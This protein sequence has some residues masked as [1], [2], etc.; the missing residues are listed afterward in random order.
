MDTQPD[1]RFTKLHTAK[2]TVYSLEIYIGYEKS[3]FGYGS[4]INEAVQKAYGQYGKEIEDIDNFLIYL[5]KYGVDI[6]IP[7]VKSK[8]DEF[9]AEKP[10]Q[11]KMRC[12]YC[13]G[14]LPSNRRRYCCTSCANKA[15]ARKAQLE[16]KKK[17]TIDLI[18]AFDTH[19][20]SN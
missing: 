15:T 20:H 16:R 17:K 4:T 5:D 10:E 18:G 13:G 7:Y 8:I 3:Y 1:F 2:G 11:N 9:N 14:L 6:S 19:D 12:Q